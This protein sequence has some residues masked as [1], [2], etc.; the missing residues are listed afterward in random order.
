MVFLSSSPS[1]LANF[2]LSIKLIFYLF[3]NLLILIKIHLQLNFSLSKYNFQVNFWSRFFPW[4]IYLALQ[5]LQRPSTFLSIK[6][7]FYYIIFIIFILRSISSFESL[8]LSL[9]IVIFS[10]FP[11]PLSAAWTCKIPLASISKVTSI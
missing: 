9:V 11:V 2:S 5:T 8:P 7:L 10:Y 4:L 3:I 6:H 1:L